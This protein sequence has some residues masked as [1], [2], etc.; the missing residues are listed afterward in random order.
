MRIYGFGLF[1]ITEW[2]DVGDI[3]TEARASHVG[4]KN[5]CRP[6]AKAKTRRTQKRLARRDGKNEI[7]DSLQ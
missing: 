4:G 5:Y 3:K 6:S 7:T 2:P 1:E